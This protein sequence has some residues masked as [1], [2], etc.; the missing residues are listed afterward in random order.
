MR[1]MICLAAAATL[2]VTA[3]GSESGDVTIRFSWWGN[4]ERA[5]ITSQA[6]DAFEKANPGITVETESTGLK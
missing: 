4:E 6:V 1:I 5:R 3:C 2:L